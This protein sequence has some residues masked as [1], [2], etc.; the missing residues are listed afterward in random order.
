MRKFCTAQIAAMVSTHSIFRSESSGY[1]MSIENYYDQTVY[2]Q[3]VT[4]STA[5]GSTESWASSSTIVAAMNP[6]S[7]KEL[8]IG[9]KETVYAD[10][11]MFCDA[12]TTIDETRRVY[13]DSK[14]YD[15]VFVKDTFKM[16]HHLK[17]LLKK[18][19]T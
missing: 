14:I 18:R 9:E 3:K 16:G 6:V 10:Y 12:G 11:K 19:D 5:W 2:V 15:V 1:G 17:V 8:F 13:W 4:T 7:G